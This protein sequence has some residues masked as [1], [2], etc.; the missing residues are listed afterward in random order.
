MFLRF[1]LISLNVSLTSQICSL[2]VLRIPLHF[3][4]K[5]SLLFF[6]LWKMCNHECMHGVLF[7][8][9]GF[10]FNDLGVPLDDARWTLKH[11][12][13]RK[14][15]QESHDS[16]PG[17]DGISYKAWRKIIS[18]AVPVLHNVAVALQDPSTVIPQDFNNAFLCCLPKKA[19]GVDP[20]LV[21]AVHSAPC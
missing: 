3:F 5:P 18:L 19:S 10:S 6:F 21:E 14:A 8:A 12:H 17:P 16:S 13:V 2:N 11:E 4:M 15:I 9:D 7:L 1:P 20:V